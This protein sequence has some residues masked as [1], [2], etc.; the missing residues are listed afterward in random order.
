MDWVIP[1]AINVAYLYLYTRYRNDSGKNCIYI[2]IHIYLHTL[3]HITQV[4][5][6]KNKNIYNMMMVLR[7]Q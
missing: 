3:K 6:I 2:F 4:L 7:S 1:I 5:R